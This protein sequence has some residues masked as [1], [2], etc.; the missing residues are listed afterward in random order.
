MPIPRKPGRCARTTEDKLNIGVKSMHPNYC[1][2]CSEIHDSPECPFKYKAEANHGGWNTKDHTRQL[3]YEIQRDRIRYENPITPDSGEPN[4]KI[5]HASLIFNRLKGGGSGGNHGSSPIDRETATIR[6][7]DRLRLLD[8]HSVKTKT[9]IP[10]I[11]SGIPSPM[12]IR[13][14]IRP[15]SLRRHKLENL[16]ISEEQMEEIAKL[17]DEAEEIALEEEEAG[18]G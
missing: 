6:Y 15:N 13:V 9:G 12:G 1:G 7:M 2:S 14:G 3:P 18:L 4:F 5:H 17:A 10:T 8:I 16:K 11:D